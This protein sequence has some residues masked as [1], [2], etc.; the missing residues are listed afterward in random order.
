MRLCYDRRAISA[1]RK[2]E[3]FLLRHSYT[4][5]LATRATA[6]LTVNQDPYVGLMPE[7][8]SDSTTLTMMPKQRQ[9]Q[10]NVPTTLIS[11]QEI[12]TFQR[13]VF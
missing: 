10:L 3:N 5:S 4:D 12:Q 9:S 2:L 11:T 13:R 1:S 6:L 7:S 8:Q